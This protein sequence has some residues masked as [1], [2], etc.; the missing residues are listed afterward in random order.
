LATA[1]VVKLTCDRRQ[2]RPKSCSPKRDQ[3]RRYKG[4]FDRGDAAPVDAEA[5]KAFRDVQIE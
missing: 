3:Q 5:A 1:A 2:R 4:K